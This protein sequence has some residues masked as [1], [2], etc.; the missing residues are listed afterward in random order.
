MKKEIRI[1]P[2]KIYKTPPVKARG[3]FK[4]IKEDAPI[5]NHSTWF[6]RTFNPILRKLFG[7]EIFSTI[8]DNKV[9]GYGIRK[10]LK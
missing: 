4:V 8:M 6:K 3:N 9:V 1:E 2:E 7:V 10:H 5:T